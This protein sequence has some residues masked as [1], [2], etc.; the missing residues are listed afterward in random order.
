MQKPVKHIDLRN[1]HYCEW[2]EFLEKAESWSREEIAQYQSSRLKQVVE[3]AYENTEAYARLYDQ[4]GLKPDEIQDLEDI[5]KLPFTEKELM[6][7]DPQKFSANIPGREY[8]TTGGSTGIPLGFYRDGISFAR[9]LAS[10]A[11][12]YYR[13]GW[14]EGDRQLVLRGTPVDTE[15]HMRYYPEFNELKGS[16]YYLTPQFMELYREKALSYKPDW[17]KCY[18]SSG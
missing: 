12:Q 6:R 16:S 2:I 4:A 9:E 3:H 10:K 18:P 8:V 11:H 17:I 15:D 1:R 13:I 14:K 5:G 7:H